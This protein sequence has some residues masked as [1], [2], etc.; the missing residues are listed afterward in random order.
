MSVSYENNNVTVNR[1]AG[2]DVVVYLRPGDNVK[3][4]FNIE[5]ASKI[6]FIG[7]DVVIEFLTGGRLTLAHYSD[8]QLSDRDKVVISDNNRSYS[9]EEFMGI[10]G[11][12]I[13]STT[14][15]SNFLVLFRDLSSVKVNEDGD[16]YGS[17]DEMLDDDSSE[18]R[19]SGDGDTEGPQNLDTLVSTSSQF[20]LRTL[21]FYTEN[22]ADVPVRY[23]TVFSN[24]DKNDD[25]GTEITP[26]LTIAP[27]VTMLYGTRTDYS[28]NELSVYNGAG[29]SANPTLMY[30]PAPIDYS[31]ESE[32]MVVRLRD[33]STIQRTFEVNLNNRVVI[34]QEMTI[35]GIPDSVTLV[36]TP[37]SSFTLEK[38]GS[39]TY[40]LKP[41][42][43]ISGTV[44]FYMQYDVNVEPVIF[45]MSI[46]VIGYNPQTET[47]YYGD[48][49]AIVDI[50]QITGPDGLGRQSDVYFNASSLSDPVWVITG[51]GNDTVYGEDYRTG[52]FETSGGDDVFY[53]SKANERVSLG[54]G[55]D[56]YFLSEG[57]DYADGGAGVNDQIV[58]S[59]EFAAEHTIGMQLNRNIIYVIDNDPENNSTTSVNF[60][61]YKLTNADDVI[62]VI[63]TD[64]IDPTVSVDA[65]EGVNSVQFRN[66]GNVIA[67]GSDLYVQTVVDGILG[68]SILV[69]NVYNFLGSEYDDIYLASNDSEITFNGLGGTDVADFSGLIAPIVYNEN[70]NAE[71]V[72]STGYVDIVIV[73]KIIGT[74][75][76]DTFYA[77]F[78]TG[79]GNNITLDG[80]GGI[81]TVSYIQS[82]Q[83]LNFNLSNSNSIIVV[84]ESGTRTDILNNIENIVASN[85]NDTF[86]FYTATASGYEYYAE[87]GI[88]TADYSDLG[89]IEYIQDQATGTVTVRR[90]GPTGGLAG[91]DTLISFEKIIGSSGNDDFMLTDTLPSNMSSNTITVDGGGGA[92]DQVTFTSVSSV[93]VYYRQDAA[94][95]YYSDIQFESAGSANYIVYDI[96]KVTLSTNDDTLFIDKGNSANVVTFDYVI[97]AGLGTDIIN[98]TFN[99]AVFEATNDLINNKLIGFEEVHFSGLGNNQVKTFGFEFMGTSFAYRDNSQSDKDIFDA[100]NVTSSAEFN[101]VDVTENIGE[102]TL[103]TGGT[104][105]IEKFEHIIGTS[106]SNTFVVDFLAADIA[107]TYDG[108]TGNNT[109]SYSTSS[110]DI[111]FNLGAAGGSISVTVASRTSVDTL[112]NFSSIVSGSGDDVFLLDSSNPYGIGI[113]GGDGID[114]ISYE[115]FVLGQNIDLNLLGSLANIEGVIGSRGADVIST[116]TDGSFFVDGSDGV[117][118]IK[119][120]SNDYVQ[121]TYSVDGVS[122]EKFN[123]SP[124]A[125]TGTDTITSIELVELTSGDDSLEISQFQNTDYDSNTFT[126]DMS[127]GDDTVKYVGGGVVL[128]F[129][130]QDS[131]GN[132]HV[133]VS[134]DY[135]SSSDTYG[136]FDRIY[137]NETFTLSSSHQDKVYLSASYFTS[138]LTTINIDAGGNSAATSYKDADLLSFSRSSNSQVIDLTSGGTIAIGGI[139]YVTTGFSA[140]EGSL[141]AD[142]IMVSDP[143]AL[144]G[145]YYV[146]GYVGV[147]RFNGANITDNLTLDLSQ[148]DA[149]IVG[150]D[151]SQ[152]EV[153]KLTIGSVATI[154]IHDI[155]MFNLTGAGNTDVTLGRYKG[156]TVNLNSASTNT[157]TYNYDESYSVYVEINRDLI[158]VQTSS[159]YDT[160]TGASSI[161]LDNDMQDAVTFAGD[162]SSASSSVLPYGTVDGGGDRN[163]ILFNQLTN[164]G[165]LVFNSD[166]SGSFAVETS[167]GSSIIASLD[168]FQNFTGTTSDDAFNLQTASSTNPLI[169]DGDAGVDTIDYS[170]YS[171]G[172]RFSLGENRI[173][174]K[175]G[176]TIV[177]YTNIERIIGTSGDDDFII[178]G[179]SS[180]SYIDAGAGNDSIDFS[181]SASAIS[182]S[183][184]SSVG[185]V[186]IVNTE[187]VR[188]TLYDDVFTAGSSTTATDYVQ[189]NV[190]NDTLDLSYYSTSG[191]TVLVKMDTSGSSFAAGEVQVSGSKVFSFAEMEIFKFSASVDADVEFS[192]TSYSQ[193]YTFD[194]ATGSS[195]S[196]D[197]SATLTGGNG[198]YIDL[199]NQTVIKG[200][201]I[202]TVTN[203]T[204]FDITGSADSDVFIITGSLSYDTSIDGVG[205]G[206]GTDTARDIL[207]VNNPGNSNVINFTT[208]VITITPSA[209]GSSTNVTFSNIESIITG[210]GDDRFIM[211]E[212]ASNTALDA[213]GGDNTADYSAFSVGITYD[214]LTARAAYVNGGS[215]IED[216]LSNI[217]NIIGSSTASNTFYGTVS[218]SYNF[219]GGSGND[220]INYSK[221]AI[222]VTFNIATSE[223][224]KGT[225]I[226]T[227]SNI[228]VIVGSNRNDYFVFNNAALSSSATYNGGGGTD[229]AT[230]NLTAGT[231][232]NIDF[233]ANTI[234][235]GGSSISASFVNFSNFVFGNDANDSITFGGESS[236]LS[237]SSLIDT[238]T[239]TD[240]VTIQNQGSSTSAS[241]E[242]VTNGLEFM[243]NNGK[244]VTILNAENFVV[245]LDE[246]YLTVND[247]VN[248]NPVSFT[249]TAETFVIIRDVNASNADLYD[250]AINFTSA[251]TSLEAFTTGGSSAGSQSF[252]NAFN[253]TLINDV[254]NYRVVI[255][256]STV[257]ISDSVSVSSISDLESLTYLNTNSATTDLVIDIVGGASGA[258]V[259]HRSSTVQDSFTGA[260]LNTNITY[261]AA[262]LASANVNLTSSNLIGSLE[263]T[264]TT[265][266][267][268]VEYALNIGGFI[269]VEVDYFYSA[270]TI[271]NRTVGISQ[272]GSSHLMQTKGFNK[273]NLTDVNDIFRINLSQFTLAELDMI[274]NDSGGYYREV[275]DFRLGEDTLE[276]SGISASNNY[277][278]VI[279]D[280]R[281]STYYETGISGENNRHMGFA[282]V[283]NIILTNDASVT[284]GGATLS[285]QTT[286][287]LEL[288]SVTFSDTFGKSIIGLPGSHH[289]NSVGSFYALN[290]VYDPTKA[291]YNSIFQNAYGNSLQINN[292]TLFNRAAA[293]DAG[294]RD[295]NAFLTFDYSAQTGDFATNN[296]DVSSIALKGTTPDAN[297]GFDYYHEVTIIG[298]GTANAM[299]QSTALNSSGT[300][301]D[302][303][304]K[305]A[306]YDPDGNENIALFYG[307]NIYESQTNGTVLAIGAA[308][309]INLYNSDL[310]I[311]GAQRWQFDY[312][313]TIVGSSTN[314]VS[315][316]NYFQSGFRNQVYR[317]SAIDGMY[318]A[319]SYS[320]PN[321]KPDSAFVKGDKFS[322][323]GFGSYQIQMNRAN[324]TFNADL[325]LYVDGMFTFNTEVDYE[326]RWG[327][328]NNDT[329]SRV[330]FVD[331]GSS[332]NPVP[333]NISV[334][335]SALGARGTA[336]APAKLVDNRTGNYVDGV[337]AIEELT[338]FSDYVDITGFVL[339]YDA[340][341]FGLSTNSVVTDRGLKIQDHYTYDTSTG[342]YKDGDTLA[343]AGGV[344]DLRVAG[345]AH[346]Y[347]EG[348]ANDGT[349]LVQAYG[350][351]NFEF[352]GFIGEDFDESLGIGNGTWG[353][354]PGNTDNGSRDNFNWFVISQDSFASV[355]TLRGTQDSRAVDV[356][357][358]QVDGTAPTSFNYIG[359]SSFSVVCG[360]SSFVASDIEF[361]SFAASTSATSPIDFG[362]L[363]YNFNMKIEEASWKSVANGGVPGLP[364]SNL[365]VHL[366]GDHQAN[367]GFVDPN[368]V[369]LNVNEYLYE[370]VYNQDVTLANQTGQSI[371]KVTDRDSGEEFWFR[372]QQVS[373]VNIYREVIG[374]PS[375]GV[376]DI[377]RSYSYID[378]NNAMVVYLGEND[379]RELGSV[380]DTIYELTV[381]YAH[382]NG[383]YD[384]F[385]VYATYYEA[386]H[387]SIDVLEYIG[388]QDNEMYDFFT[389]TVE[390]YEAGVDFYKVD[391]VEAFYQQQEGGSS[392]YGYD[393]SYDSYFTA[394]QSSRAEQLEE[395]ALKEQ[396]AKELAKQ[397]AEEEMQKQEQAEF[398]KQQDLA[399]QL[400]E[401]AK[402]EQEEKEQAKEEAE[403]EMQAKQDEEEAND[404]DDDKEEGRFTLEEDSDFDFAGEDFTGNQ[405]DNLL[406]NND[407]ISF[408]N[409]V[410]DANSD[411][412]MKDLFAQ[413]KDVVVEQIKDSI[414]QDISIVDDNAHVDEM[415]INED[416]TMSYANDSLVDSSAEVDKTFDSNINGN[417]N[418]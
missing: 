351:E 12:K 277:N 50:H 80:A 71:V 11:S 23:T 325:H 195:L 337:S 340:N 258:L 363:E 123:G 82:T 184:G 147:D 406:D 394:Y 209:G 146:N 156:Y 295:F 303:M 361:L 397:Q 106:S 222:G 357:E 22:D 38:V 308:D 403:E 313:F 165:G 402:Q 216:T 371:L 46:S 107:V 364:Q 405:E 180:L 241:V 317:M 401:Q 85:N 391:I 200:G 284:D 414:I 220:T 301:D 352:T 261:D 118:S 186:T 111:R 320:T 54:D 239:G 247:F 253:V 142:T 360:N 407:L 326:T 28:N 81:D 163:S 290:A 384:Y 91:T 237:N 365:A 43:A 129:D 400:E 227:Y 396:E 395:Q 35:E 299:I 214:A 399:K 389:F 416:N 212:N 404:N 310:F 372:M 271:A 157:V 206:S 215:N 104:V 387:G 374:G 1:T 4:N 9:A 203:K 306:T 321:T 254:R 385:R 278:F 53:G 60:A 155:E 128:D 199:T 152:T 226:D 37:D 63:N 182:V 256:Q 169:I 270:E 272:A 265:G 109:I 242:A 176:D 84:T 79:V 275:V 335:Y 78:T 412:N 236:G 231:V 327:S 333:V 274:A 126:V 17:A 386:Q 417:S 190:G 127:S 105:T 112:K 338:A 234:S 332:V 59:D 68:S 205:N 224:V 225:A 244:S 45:D 137:N 122:V 93:N 162:Y 283:E 280:G 255:D 166:T 302:D 286:Q 291:S 113:D 262:N 13:S 168:N 268:S 248:Y 257:A 83:N 354:Q 307:N 120:A 87:G 151:I 121:A 229:T 398:E 6:N 263:L 408:D 15:D 383:D 192:E 230:F 377:S 331:S 108:A 140:F 136:S 375:S 379:F 347:K 10:V 36:P 75:Y 119:F 249:G 160:I 282:N 252:I 76:A 288:N 14:N 345:Q 21:N 346:Y 233:I 369:N 77:N 135:N 196:L 344:F 232:I 187:G 74:D 8:I 314:E 115:N 366:D 250:M 304:S 279:L 269:G 358:I 138:G 315:Q 292:S 154:N 342:N 219:V 29:I 3:L 97:D 177:T 183:I 217:F 149:Y 296:T 48:K 356:V 289:S 359:N 58:I 293:S 260:G 343:V 18:S 285:L 243:F 44:S 173:L 131:S 175:S 161:V 350:F 65:L 264:N 348:Y 368:I 150:S 349:G 316:T 67:I 380:E 95:E 27:T 62:E 92:F 294:A 7:N 319:G 370:N 148:D 133:M 94:G 26:V 410:N 266:D 141:G 56:T 297:A 41:L 197:Y 134:K 172:L 99:N 193:S 415:V 116:L 178:G 393:V 189:G 64:G 89:K 96:D 125:S 300:K 191:S 309:K 55:D 324:G 218:G 103:G 409:A 31:Y 388:I 174:N 382:M 323:E 40:A 211:Q 2:D 139:N 185:S 188:G 376:D 251:S 25:I 413:A 159:G 322:V 373:S 318:S 328:G 33:S 330:Y 334:E 158:N 117:D 336:Y 66:S 24:K 287:N 228:D 51:S 198:L 124:A 341:T 213:G 181:L 201:R 329:S 98:I 16:Q 88:D 153:N 90:F 378:E 418:Q 114:Y 144:S 411:K 305:I 221:S 273:F 20:Q 42:G 143:S 362:V 204:E 100:S 110:E 30:N 259:V 367:A 245:N 179:S 202:D 246:I 130:N 238:G 5:D 32:D 381:Q 281:F 49:D 339:A 170:G 70:G 61:E 73:D 267:I 392:S 210:D 102:L 235:V 132:Y 72:K 171:T 223:V 39:E 69:K 52:T 34:L 240:T 145:D 164:T 355:S 353:Y 298:N 167:S 312:G 207:I 47:L 276:M 194:I 390:Q 19:P 57:V 101:L 311:R 208:G 86:E